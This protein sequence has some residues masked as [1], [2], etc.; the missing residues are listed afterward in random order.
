MYCCIDMGKTGWR[1]ISRLRSCCSA[2]PTRSRAIGSAASTSP[3]EATAECVRSMLTY[4]LPTL[5]LEA[6]FIILGWE[7]R[8]YARSRAIGSAAAVSLFI[9]QIVSDT[10]H[11]HGG[12][13]VSFN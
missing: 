7:Q 2:A 3:R 5:I 10:R 8:F 13:C 9:K 11:P 12:P 6:E 1:S 4:C